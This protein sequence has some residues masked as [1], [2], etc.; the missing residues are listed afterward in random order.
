MKHSAVILLAGISAILCA[1]TPLTPQVRIQSN[2][3]LFAALSPQQQ[4]LVSQGQIARGM[5]PEAVFL[6]WGKADS[7][8]EG[9]RGPVPVQRWDYSASRPV[10]TTSV[11]GSYGFGR[12]GRGYGFGAGPEVTYI[13]YRTASVWFENNRVTEWE[14]L[15]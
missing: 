7:I 12:Y 14:R 6:A 1:C 3:A 5:G 13:P 4:T 10:H 11:F 15:R 8:Y 9:G 2:P